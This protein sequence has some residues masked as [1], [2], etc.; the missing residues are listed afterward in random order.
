MVVE[1]ILSCSVLSLAAEYMGFFWAGSL[2]WVW[3]VL[4]TYSVLF[5]V[6]NWRARLTFRCLIPHVPC[7]QQQ[8]WGTFPL[9]GKTP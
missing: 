7:C 2:L 4:Q 3:L 1:Y 6:A 8:P 5:R 9:S